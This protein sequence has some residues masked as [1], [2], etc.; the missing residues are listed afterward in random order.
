VH[1]LRTIDDATRLNT[2]IRNAARVAVIGAGWIGSEVAASARQMGARVVLIDPLDVPL[3]R[4]LG[5]EIGEVFRRLHA[6]HGVDL[7]LGRSVSA[8]SGL[9]RVEEVVLADGSVE[10]ADVVVVGIGVQP[11]VELAAAGGLALDNGVLVDEHLETSAPGIYAAGDIANAAHPLLRRRLRVEHWAN[12]LNQG[13]TA[14]SNAAG[15]T[16]VYERLPY[17]FSD[18]FDLGMEYVGHGSPDDEVVIRG[19]LNTRQFI[20]FW[21]RHR[22]VTAAMNVNVW[23]VTDDLQ[24][25]IRAG[26]PVDPARLADPDI[27]LTQLWSPAP[28]AHTR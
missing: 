24:A 20:A 1:Y 3:Q 17:F 7:R 26:S 16:G 13:L 25:L 10:K 12:A 22:L 5:P 11:R 23:D 14:G 15:A 18:Q 6:D 27:P 28:A 19:D 9:G 2:A 4:V 8:L 21:H